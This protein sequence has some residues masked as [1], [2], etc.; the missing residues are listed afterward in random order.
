M[1]IFGEPT[2]SPVL[3]PLTVQAAIVL[4]RR[5]TEKDWFSLTR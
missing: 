3:R 1:M 4:E 2:D 5:Y